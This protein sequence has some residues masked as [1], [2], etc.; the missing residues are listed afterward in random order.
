MDDSP[1]YRVYLDH[2]TSSPCRRET[3]DA[4]AGILEAFP[5]IEGSSNACG[6]AAA[7]LLAERREELALMTGAASVHFTS[8]GGEAN[9]AAVLSVGRKMRGEGRGRIVSSRLEHLSV[10]TAL[11]RLAGEGSEIAW[12]TTG[13]DG[14]VD[15]GE[16]E[17]LLDEGT[18]LVTVQH[19]SRV[20]GIV[21][22]VDRIIPLL[23]DRR[24]H[25]HCD[26][27]AATGR[28]G[29]D[30]GEARMT[31]ASISGR[32]A[33][34]GPGA[35]ALLWA[36]DPGDVMSNF[37]GSASEASL[38]AV[39]GMMTALGETRLGVEAR[40]RMMNDLR[41]ELLEGLGKRGMPF[42]QVGGRTGR[43]PGAC[44]ARLGKPVPSVFHARMERAGVVLPCPRSAGRLAYLRELGQD[45]SEPERFLGFCLSTSNS[46]VDVEYFL[47]IVTECAA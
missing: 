32:L 42:D 3:V 1:G 18:G 5:G 17:D 41:D 30:L 11:R 4:I 14:T 29:L 8:G 26:C 15:A 9:A 44:L 22:P 19:S 27:C 46:I 36:D 6:R 38:P 39:T 20:S 21:Q 34:G 45:T 13:A 12:L 37:H 2:L 25:Y 28:T 33:G 31:S 16:L 24:V 35:G 23:G 10:L 7:R 40:A 47:R 43:L